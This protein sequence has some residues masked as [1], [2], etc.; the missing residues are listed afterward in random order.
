MLE[1]ELHSLPLAMARSEQL[2]YLSFLRKYMQGVIVI[3]EEFEQ[4]PMD[5]GEI[6]LRCKI[7]RTI[8]GAVK[9][10]LNADTVIHLINHAEWCRQRKAPRRGR[11]KRTSG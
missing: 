7:C 2:T 10:P 3:P 6:A 1:V 11:T 5:T 4:V 9:L 8:K